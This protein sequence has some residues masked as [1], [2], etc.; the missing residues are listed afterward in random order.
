MNATDLLIQFGLISPSMADAELAVEAVLFTAEASAEHWSH[1][2]E[3][4][5][6]YLISGGTPYTKEEL[7]D[8]DRYASSRGLTFED[9][10]NFHL[11][12]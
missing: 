12:K 11:S 2:A 8:A 3:T 7:A 10:L 9:V 1:I 6:R 5:R 4:Y